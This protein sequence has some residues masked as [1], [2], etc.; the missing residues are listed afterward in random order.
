[1]KKITGKMLIE[2]EKVQVI[3][4]NFI[5]KEHFHINAEVFMIKEGRCN[6]IINGKSQM[7]SAGDICF[8]ESSSCTL[9]FFRNT[10]SV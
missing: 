4:S 5:E 2:H 7:L 6:V 3:N 8:F 10:L 1:M 9:C